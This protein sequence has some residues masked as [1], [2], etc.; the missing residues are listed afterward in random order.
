MYE[1][2]Y[3][4]EYEQKQKVVAAAA[5]AQEREEEI[6]G[7]CGGL[8]SGP[9][10]STKHELGQQQGSVQQPCSLHHVPSRR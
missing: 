6:S 9:T 5:A 2:E 8:F 1:S 4:G 3:G 10:W 7:K